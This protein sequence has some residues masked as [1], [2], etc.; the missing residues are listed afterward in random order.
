ML[1]CLCCGSVDD[2][3][4]F[5]VDDIVV[6]VVVV[7]FFI[8]QVM[9]TFER[10]R[11]ASLDGGSDSEFVYDEGDEPE[12]IVS[13]DE[14][15]DEG[16]EMTIFVKTMTGNV[17]TLKV[18]ASD[19]IDNVKSQI[20]LYGG[21]PSDQQGIIFDT[22]HL[23]DDRTLSDYNIQEN[24]T[25]HLAL[26]FRGGGKRGRIPAQEKQ[27]KA[28]RCRV[29]REEV[30][31]LMLVAGVLCTPIGQLVQN[32][33]EVSLRLSDRPQQ[34]MTE[35]LAG[36]DVAKLGRLLE[37]TAVSNN[38]STRILALART[39]F[40]RSFDELEEVSL[41]VSKSREVCVGY[42]ELMMLSQYGD[43]GATSHGRP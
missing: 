17:F 16:E 27:D 14:G 4:T 20:E 3:M 24:S 34:V 21:V 18:K 38:T 6:A 23:E 30:G 10:F 2:A 8:P 36:M 13:D 41:Q 1:C 26:R 37:L 22:S 25:I 35:M 5:I 31:T 28:G 33:G 43:E 12:F 15:E 39:I 32:L 7:V 42:A 9:E 11:I 40:D 19:T 29:L